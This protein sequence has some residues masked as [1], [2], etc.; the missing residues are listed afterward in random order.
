MPPAT[1]PELEDR[2][3]RRRFPFSIW[4]VVAPV[5]LAACV[6]VIVSIASDAG[7][8][9]RGQETTVTRTTGSA[10]SSQA[11]GAILYRVKRGE[12]LTMIAVRFGISLE[13]IKALNPKLPADG[14]VPAGR[15]I[16]LR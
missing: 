5:A 6:F 7:W 4:T 9:R 14:S 11:G 8:T 10:G 12:T 16:R 1:A 13:R 3:K 2:A 15:R